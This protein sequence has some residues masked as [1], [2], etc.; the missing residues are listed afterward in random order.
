MLFQCGRI[1]LTS[2]F[3]TPQA[4]IDWLADWFKNEL[5]HYSG[6]VWLAEPAATARDYTIP[7]IYL[8][9]TQRLL[10]PVRKPRNAERGLSRLKNTSTG[11]PMMLNARTRL[12]ASLYRFLGCECIEQLMYGA[13]N[14][15]LLLGSRTGRPDANGRFNIFHD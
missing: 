13:L 6:L 11:S 15:A 3:G 12:F 2:I 9:F 1:E 7:H 8:K 5:F 4:A 10:T 14:G